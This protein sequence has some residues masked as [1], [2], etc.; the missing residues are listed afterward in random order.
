[1][2]VAIPAAR[3]GCHLLI[4]KPLADDLSRVDE[5]R[6]AASKGG[7]RILMGFQFRFHPM[8]QRARVLIQNGALGK[9]LT[10]HA[11]WGEYLPQ[12]HP[13]EDYRDRYAARKDLGGG[14]IATLTH[15]LDYLRFL[16]GEIETLTAIHGHISPLEVDVEDI[17]R[18]STRLN[19]SHIQKSR[20]PSSA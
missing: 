12:W 14:A 5:L 15:P 6:A 8:I 10:A 13:W 17:D 20:M 1:M 16:L 4:E 9:T 19:S 7:S 18:K 11:H 2:D 3:A